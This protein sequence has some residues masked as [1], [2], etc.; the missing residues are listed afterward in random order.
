MSEGAK[1]QPS[2][3]SAYVEQQIDE[4]TPADVSTLTGSIRNAQ[5][6]VSLIKVLQE[7]GEERSLLWLIEHVPG[8]TSARQLLFNVGSLALSRD[9]VEKRV[10][11]E[12][13]SHFSLTEAGRAFDCP[14]QSALLADKLAQLDACLAEKPAAPSFSSFVGAASRS[15]RRT[16]D[17]SDAPSEAA[18]LDRKALGMHVLK[19][20]VGLVILWLIF[21]PLVTSLL[22]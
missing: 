13:M 4:A 6:C 22:R 21:W 7:E 14:A 12:G 11:D 8:V 19:I 18:P 5:A 17:S 3:L 9:L 2:L 16:S 1:E 15:A 10:D 20:A